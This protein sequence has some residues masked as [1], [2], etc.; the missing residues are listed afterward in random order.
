MNLQNRIKPLVAALG[1]A[2]AIAALPA[3]AATY[4]SAPGAHPDN[5]DVTEMTLNSINSTDCY[6]VVSGNINSATDLN[7][8]NLT[9]GSNFALLADTGGVSTG[10]FGGFNFSLSAT[11]TKTGT[12]ILTATDPDPVTPPS[13][14][15][16][17]DLVGALKA[18]DRFALYF[19]DDIAVAAG[20]NNGT[21]KISFVNNG[22][23]IPDLSHLALFV[24]AGDGVLPP[25]EVP[26]PAS[27]G[28]LGLG[29]AGLAAI[30]R[31]R[32]V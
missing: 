24:R 21:W 18:S 23:Q 8:L 27:L 2:L 3:S 13:L 20:D 19:F 28:L 22:G 16:S 14:P 5:L 6:G 25:I 10:S 29:M 26:E 32:V 11:G 15:T 12:W 31:R 30:R 17:L 9:W 4:C 7:S 1:V